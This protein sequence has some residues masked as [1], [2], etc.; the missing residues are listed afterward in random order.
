MAIFVCR[1]VQKC[2]LDRGHQVILSKSGELLL[3]IS[4]KCEKHN[5]KH[6]F[7]IAHW[8]F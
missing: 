7:T 3:K 4:K 1:F 2:K 5:N 6:V 8:D